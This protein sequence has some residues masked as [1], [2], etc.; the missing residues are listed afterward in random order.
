MELLN[1]FEVMTNKRCLR[2]IS[3]TILINL[4]LHVQ[5]ELITRVWNGGKWM[6]N[7]GN[8]SAREESLRKILSVKA[9]VFFV[10]FSSLT[11][12]RIFVFLNKT[13]NIQYT[14]SKDASNLYIQ[15]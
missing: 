4:G 10:S 13:E 7:S 14:N 12:T 1:L 3:V 6:Q 8:I 15:Q 9:I 5:C 2:T 11:K